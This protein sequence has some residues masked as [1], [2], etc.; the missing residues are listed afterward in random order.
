MPA[1]R[2]RAAAALLLALLAGCSSVPRSTQTPR[3][4]L[5]AMLL[6]SN[7]AAEGGIDVTVRMDN[8]NDFPIAVDSLRFTARIGG[9]G[10]V[11]GRYAVP[12][13]IAALDTHELSVTVATDRISSPSR[14]AAVAEGSARLLP[15][16]LEGELVV[17]GRPPRSLAFSASERLPLALPR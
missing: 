17:G 9:E 14:L 6:S 10:Y 16:E 12:F 8:L 2:G 1:R 15:Y 7:A 5:T 4:L 13:T 3:V 11:E